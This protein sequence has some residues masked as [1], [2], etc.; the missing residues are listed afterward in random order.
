MKEVSTFGVTF[1]RD[2]G[3]DVL[4]R[5]AEI[6]DTHVRHGSFACG[7]VKDDP[8]NKQLIEILGRAG[9]KP[10]PPIPGRDRGPKEYSFHI[11]REYD[12]SDFKATEYHKITVPEWQGADLVRDGMIYLIR[13]KCPMGVEL[14][15]NDCGYVVSDRLRKDIEATGLRGVVFHETALIDSFEESK[16]NIATWNEAGEPPWWQ[17]TSDLVLPPLSPSCTLLDR[18]GDPYR[19]GGTTGCLIIEGFYVPAELHYQRR[20]LASVGPFDLALTRERF[21]LGAANSYPWKVVSRAMYEFLTK[22][23]VK[24]GYVPVRMDEN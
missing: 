15:G 22:R 6:P 11:R 5:I 7:F 17:I 16:R 4:E 20:A 9:C 14:A 18:N 1:A 24:A 12:E 21:G 19:E 3:E 23:G 10:K 13:S 8:R 2:V